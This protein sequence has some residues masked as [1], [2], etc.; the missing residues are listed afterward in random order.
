MNRISIFLASMLLAIA[1]SSAAMTFVHPGTLDGKQELD[2]VKSQIAV[3]AEP[4][5]SQ[6]NS[7]ISTENLAQAPS[8]ATTINANDNTSA[9]NSRDD[10]RRAYGNALAW[11]LTGNE[12]YAKQAVAILNAWSVLTSITATDQQKL[13]QGG[14]LGALLGPAA[15]IMLGYPGWAV[16]DIANFR[17][18]LKLAFYPVLNVMSTWNGNV[19]LTQIDAMMSI[20]VF[21]EDETEFNLGLTRLA[22]R[23]PN[24]FY[25][26]TDSKPNVT[27]WS[28]P[29][30][31]VDGLTQ[32]TCRD[33]DHHAQFAMSAA[34][35]AAE[36]A[37]HQGVDVYTTYRSRFMAT[38]ELMGLQETS[39]SMQGTCSNNVTSSDVYDTWEIGYNHYHTRL[40][41]A[42]PNSLAMIMQNRSTQSNQGAWNIFYETL[43]HAD[44]KYVTSA[45]Q[46]KIH[47]VASSFVVLHHDGICEIKASKAGMFEVTALALDGSLLSHSN[48]QIAAGKSCLVS[49]GLERARAGMY[50][51]RVHS[52]EGTQVLKFMK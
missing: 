6:L 11:Y 33:N 26:T 45:V 4:W 17:A 32:E 3:G 27:V 52:A 22:S 31:W 35:G 47:G 23:V 15:D 42:M 1:F 38:E 44:I 39:G 34:I 20:A 2:Y 41:L 19:D 28:T 40:G 37:W 25:L 51:V 49:L 8:P 30:L 14:W 36:V 9:N 48:V 43:T 24:Y 21:M 13:L 50:L 18:M 7:M 10:S 46:G 29:T 5:T 12:T 16:S